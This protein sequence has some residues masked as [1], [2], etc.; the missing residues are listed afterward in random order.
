MYSSLNP[1]KFRTAAGT[2][3]D[4][5]V[6]AGEGELNAHKECLVLNIFKTALQFE[7]SVL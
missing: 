4:S 1:Q 5:A 2:R 3:A 6:G 7:H